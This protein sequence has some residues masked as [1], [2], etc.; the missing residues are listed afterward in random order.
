MA[1]HKA[2]PLSIPGSP[3]RRLPEGDAHITRSSS[4]VTAF[5]R[6]L[7]RKLVEVSGKPSL[8]VILWDGEAVYQGDNPVAQLIIRD[9]KTLWRILIDPEFWFGDAFSTGRAEVSGNIVAFLETVYRGRKSG[10]PTSWFRRKLSG[11]LNRPTSTT[12]GRARENIHH[13]YDLGNEFYRMWLDDELVY[14]C[15]YYPTAQTT[16]AAAQQAKMEHVCRKL[17]LQPGQSVVEAGCGWGALALYMAREYGVKVTAYNISTEQVA[18]ARQRACAEGLDDC[19]T[20]V[21]DDYRNIEGRYDAFVSVGMLEHVG[22]GAYRTLGT[23]IRRCLQPG[24]RGLIHSI[25]RNRPRRNNPWIER[26][27]FPGSCPPSLK[28]MMDIFEDSDFSVLDIENLRL[29]Y[30]H[31][32]KDWLERYDAVMEQVTGMYDYSFA[33]AWRLYLAGS[34]AAFSTGGLQ[35]FQVVFAHGADNGVPATRDHI[36]GQDDTDRPSDAF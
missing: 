8:S 6:W 30:A 12:I 13:H 20:I 32:C 23:V 10:M 27:I 5:D 31:T 22:V 9:R 14:T 17:Q 33:R 16:L 28:Q 25:G 36:Y 1:K 11:C 26:R 29:H 15:A 18:Y 24:G 34:V 35:L 2:H 19:V 7:A 4:P 3:E 21:E